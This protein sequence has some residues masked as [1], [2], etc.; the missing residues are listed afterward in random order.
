MSKLGP[1]T[2]CPAILPEIQNPELRPLSDLLIK[3]HGN[4]PGAST[5]DPGG[6]FQ[7]ATFPLVALDAQGNTVAQLSVIPVSRR[8]LPAFATAY[9]WELDPLRP[10]ARPC[11]LSGLVVHAPLST[12]APP[13]ADEIGE[14]LSFDFF[15]RTENDALTPP[16][17]SP[18]GLVFLGLL[19]LAA[20]VAQT[21]GASHLVIAAEPG[22]SPLLGPTDIPWK[23]MGPEGKATARP[24]VVRG[25]DAWPI[26][27]SLRGRALSRMPDKPDA[28]ARR[29]EFDRAAEE[30]FH[31]GGFDFTVAREDP[32]RRQI[33]ELRRRIVPWAPQTRLL[34]PGRGPLMDAYDPWSVHAAAT[35]NTGRVVGS[36]RLILNSPLGLPALE[37]ARPE[38][39]QRLEKSRKIAELS[40]LCLAQPYASAFADVWSA[41]LSYP[42]AAPGDT[43]T[44]HQR[45]QG[46]ILILGLFRLLYRISK[47]I[48]LTGWVV[49]LRSDA[50]EALTRNGYKLRAMGSPTD[51]AGRAPFF[52]QF[53]ESEHSLFSVKN[54]RGAAADLSRLAKGPERGGQ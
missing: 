13:Q 36:F 53:I 50:A 7:G 51:A 38:E 15:P 6:E 23:P 16:P 11:Q 33:F 17:P 20:Q 40:G 4:A 26:L 28:S 35:D 48:R 8:G 12:E 5:V 34:Q 47:S 49:F 3:E 27:L 39:L 30:Q 19:H 22:L 2:F 44:S 14:Y 37:A 18:R 9:P 21:L 31:L 52:L 24:F 45:H 54:I 43:P 42:V 32:V 1:F 46:A 41:L 25:T 10:P 29:P